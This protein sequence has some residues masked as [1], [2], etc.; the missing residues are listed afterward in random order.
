MNTL[1]WFVVGTVAPFGGV[2][3]GP[4]WVLWGPV[5]MQLAFRCKF[6]RVYDY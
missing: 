6:K 5:T 4:S 2:N 3:E 1:Y